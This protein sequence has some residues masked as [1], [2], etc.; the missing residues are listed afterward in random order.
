MIIVVSSIFV[1][2]SDY[3]IEET[4][5]VGSGKICDVHHFVI[6]TVCPGVSDPPPPSDG[7][8]SPDHPVDPMQVTDHEKKT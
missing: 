7:S 6:F 5:K 4:I 1:N 3:F 8:K 2:I